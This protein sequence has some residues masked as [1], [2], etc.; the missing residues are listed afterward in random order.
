MDSMPCGLLYIL[1]N[2]VKPQGHPGYRNCEFVYS[3]LCQCLC[4]ALRFS[5]NDRERHVHNVGSQ[6]FSDA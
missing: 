6:T 1:K 3:G 5:V 4:V 2:Q